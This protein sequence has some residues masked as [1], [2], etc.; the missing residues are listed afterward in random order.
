MSVQSTTRTLAVL[1][2]AIA[3][4]AGAWAQ[5]A[6]LPAGPWRSPASATYT[7]PALTG[8]ALYLS[9]DVAKDGSFRGV[10]GQYFC[11][12]Y[13]G[14]YGIS[15]YSCSRIGS[16]RVS[17]RFGP[18]RQG[19]IEL[20]TLGRSA[21]TWAA[22]SA[23][24]LAIDLPK[25]WQGKDAV[26]Y[27]ARMTRDGK[28]VAAAASATSAARDEGPLLS[29]NALYREFKKDEP[30]AQARHG[31][32]TLVLDARRGNLIALSD[33]GAAVHVAD[34][35]QTRAL[36]LYFRDLKELGGIGEGA[37]F[38]FKCRVLDFAYQY[39]QMENCSIVR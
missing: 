23:G 7:N 15:I 36:V 17:G 21:F 12:A 4:A 37:Q 16:H 13:P 18:A 3:N 34:G 24:E 8:A 6:T 35:F 30:A 22:P 1:A 9:I 39:V 11:T 19:L 31:G 25:D 26:L 32:K 28:P 38:R 10:W 5:D 20:D 33:G 27:R 2:T 14:A 29:A